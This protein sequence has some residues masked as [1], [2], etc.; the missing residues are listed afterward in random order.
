VKLASWARLAIVGLCFFHLSC[1]VNI[2]EEF[3]DKDTDLAKLHEAQILISGGSFDSAITVISSMSTAYQSRSEVKSLF[4]SAYAGRCGLNF[5]SFVDVLSNMGSERLLLYLMQSRNGATLAQQSDC[6]QAISIVE[7][8]SADATE[9]SDDENIFMAFV[10][11]FQIGTI[12][13]IYADT[14]DDGTAD[15]VDGCNN[16]SFA[17]ADAR[18]YSAALMIALSS[19]NAVANASVGGDQISE[20]NSVC[21]ALGNPPFNETDIC[22][23]TNPADF[24]ASEL[25][26]LRTLAV[27]NSD[28]GVGSCAG[29]VTACLCP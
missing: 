10:A 19:I 29:D 23:K 4:A 21:T 6:A 27:E 2:L 22:T 17:E 28:V 1:S 18:A 11:F 26:L 5:L 8:I 20:I 12:L 7:S 3:G 16:A 25:R 24:D 9:R 13:N 14:N 15:W